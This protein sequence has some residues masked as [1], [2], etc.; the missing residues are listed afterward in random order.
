MTLDALPAPVLAP[1]IFMISTYC[2][3]GGC[4]AV[5]KLPDGGR[6]VRDAKAADDG[7]VL[8]FTAAEWTAF[9]AGVK[10]GEFD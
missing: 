6:V 5:A 3:H 9:V 8:E 7:P 2:A 1:R 4:V 10:D